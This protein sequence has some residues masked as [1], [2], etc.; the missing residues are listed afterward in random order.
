MNL[1]DIIYIVAIVVALFAGYKCGFLERISM[2]IGIIFGLF[3]ATVLQDSAV[4][5]LLEAT[6]WN[7]TVVAITAYAAIMVSRHRDTSRAASA[8]PG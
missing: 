4:K 7:G 1:L 3:N 5:L 6:G 8:Q 2:T